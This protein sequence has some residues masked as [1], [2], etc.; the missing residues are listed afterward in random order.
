MKTILWWEKGGAGF[1]AR[2]GE[3]MLERREKRKRKTHIGFKKRMPE[4]EPRRRETH[5][6]YRGSTRTD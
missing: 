6:L 1:S 5:E 2:K 3:E 4:E